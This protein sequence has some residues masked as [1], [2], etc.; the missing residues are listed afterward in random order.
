MVEEWGVDDA[1]TRSLYET[2]MQAAS[3]HGNTDDAHQLR[4]KFL[5]SFQGKAASAEALAQAAIAVGEVVKNPSVFQ[6]DTYMQLDAIK[7]LKGDAKQAG[8][9]QLLELF[10]QDDLAAL[11]DFNAKNGAVL[12]ALGLDKEACVFKM[13]LLTL[14]SLATR[15]ESISYAEIAAALQVQE[16]EVETWAIKAM[17]RKLMDAKLDQLNRCLIV[18][19]CAPRLFSNNEWASMRAKLVGWRDRMQ[20]LQSVLHATRARQQHELAMMQQ[21]MQMQ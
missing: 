5:S 8:V 7:A 17:E 19:H 21:Q 13:R 16:T 6:F 11:N 18:N 2:L 12:S 14:T 4:I 9:Y 3:T 15:Q 1:K 10:S 20:Q